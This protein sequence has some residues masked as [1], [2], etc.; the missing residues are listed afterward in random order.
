MSPQ[1]IDVKS[2]TRQIDYQIWEFAPLKFI[3]KVPLMKLIQRK[4]RISLGAQ[5]HQQVL[6]QVHCDQPQYQGKTDEF[7]TN[8]AVSEA[9]I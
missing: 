1:S 8:S 5:R 7:V 3:S 9:E 6:I 4:L 2:V